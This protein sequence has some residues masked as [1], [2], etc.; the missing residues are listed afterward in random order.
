M[1]NQQIIDYLAK[2]EKKLDFDRKSR[3][4]ESEMK[5]IE[6]EILTILQANKNKPTLIGEY[7][8]CLENGNKYPKW[9]DEFIKH[10]G[11]VIAQE[12]I[13]TTKP[14]KQLKIEKG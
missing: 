2:K 1:D 10:V 9:K 6:T 8:I 11:S 3:K 12:V 14:N 5:T 4:L 13:D 7:V